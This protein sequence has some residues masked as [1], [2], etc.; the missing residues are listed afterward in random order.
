MRLLGSWL[1]AS[2]V[3]LGILTP[4]FGGD[5]KGAEDL[6]W[7]KRIATEFLEVVTADPSGEKIMNFTGL[8][9][10]ELAKSLPQASWDIFLGQVWS[11]Y[12]QAKITSEEM[13]PNRSEVIFTGILKGKKNF[14]EGNNFPDADFTLRVAKESENGRWSIRFIRIRERAAKKTE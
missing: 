1:I 7:A 10:P 8:L 6:K 3:I 2:L 11:H 14:A 4:A 9:S 5:A 13:A 12:H